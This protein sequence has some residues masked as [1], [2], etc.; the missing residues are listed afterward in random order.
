VF[1]TMTPEY[2]VPAISSSGMVPS[3]SVRS[4]SIG[5]PTLWML[6]RVISSS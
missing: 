6:S 2:T 4:C 1:S 3:S 5:W